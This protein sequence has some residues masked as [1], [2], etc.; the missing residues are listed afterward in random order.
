MEKW[1]TIC[2]CGIVFIVYYSVLALIYQF[3]HF[4]YICNNSS[5]GDDDD[6][7]DSILVILYNTH[8]LFLLRSLAVW[9]YVTVSV[10][11]FNFKT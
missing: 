5:D 9:L 8:N 6:D 10:I 1:T 2:S 4:K 3:R 7:D 11:E